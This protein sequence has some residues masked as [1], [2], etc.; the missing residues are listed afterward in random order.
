VNGLFLYDINRCVSCLACVAGCKLTN[1]GSVPWRMVISDNERAY[2]GLPVHNLSLACN[3]CENPACL[4]GC[5]AKAYHVDQVTGAVILDEKKC[6]GCNYCYWCCPFDAPHYDHKLR[7]VQKCHFCNERLLSG[8]EPACTSACPTG[9]LSYMNSNATTELFG[10][11]TETGLAPR[12]SFIKPRH[13]GNNNIPP[14]G[15]Y[16]SR[17]KS[18][19]PLS[20]EWSLLAF[21]Y[22]SSLLF[23]FSFSAISGGLFPGIRLFMIMSVICLVIPLLHLGHPWRAWRAVSNLRHSPL[24]VEIFILVLFVIGANAGYITGIRWLS[25]GSFI[26]GLAL[27]VAIDNVYTAPDSRNVFRFHPGQLF[28]TGLLFA[29]LF[30]IEYRAL[31]FIVVLKLIMN[32]RVR[33]FTIR[34]NV[35]IIIG[36]AYNLLI[37]TATIFLLTA[38]DRGFA[39]ILYMIAELINRAGYYIDF[40]PPGIVNEY[41]KRGKY[42]EKQKRDQ[43]LK[44]TDIS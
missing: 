26:A 23:A 17:T 22:L 24:S 32:N 13:S 6:L 7:N 25:A 12:I 40:S 10:I 35:N 5:P 28:L 21:T 19:V 41:I 4:E 11:I 43:Q 30:G 39:I 16:S 14:S 31:L 27:M 29:S 18:K 9:A 42:Y 8:G 36:L 33:F 3:H 15:A 37:L 34:T 38:T 20:G 1:R 44:S 2:P